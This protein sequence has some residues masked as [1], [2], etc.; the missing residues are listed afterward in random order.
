MTK[1]KS[2]QFTN[3]YDMWY[4]FRATAPINQSYKHRTSFISAVAQL[5][6]THTCDH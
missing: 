3:V 4:S 1:F 5:E 2:P 6:S